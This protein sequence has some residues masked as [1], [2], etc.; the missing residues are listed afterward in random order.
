MA[1]DMQGLPSIGIG[2]T[3]AYR[4]FMLNTNRHSSFLELYLY[5]KHKVSNGPYNISALSLKEAVE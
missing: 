4:T 5:T 1:Q 2:F 3:F